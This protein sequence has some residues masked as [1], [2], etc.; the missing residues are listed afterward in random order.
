MEDF[1]NTHQ[2]PRGWGTHLNFIGQLRQRA[3]RFFNDIQTKRD[4]LKLEAL[5]IAFFDEING[6]H[7]KNI[8][9]LNGVNWR[10]MQ[11]A[12]CHIQA[13]CCLDKL[14]SFV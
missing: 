13:T 3:V 11:L 7:A 10:F 1:W 6:Y 12:R 9:P 4:A 8:I 2:P 14:M 5:Q